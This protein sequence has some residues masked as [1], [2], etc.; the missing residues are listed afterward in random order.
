MELPAP[1]W[2]AACFLLS[3][4]DNA[5]RERLGMG[6]QVVVLDDDPESCHALSEVLAA[7]GFETLPFL[8]GETAWD[9]IESRHV[10]PDAVV[11]DIRMPGL[12][13]V[14]FLRRIRSAFPEIPVIL[15]SAFPDERVWSEALRLGAL[16][17]VPKPIRADALAQLL[18]D[19]MPGAHNGSAQTETH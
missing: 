7:E 17:V 9:V 15:V 10:R 14:A 19:A 6:G 11:S 3:L 12:D 18:R 13:G 16:D 4:S 5:G 1:W 2:H 8:S